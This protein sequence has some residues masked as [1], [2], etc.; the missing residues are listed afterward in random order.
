MCFNLSTQLEGKCFVKLLFQKWIQPFHITLWH[1]TDF[2]ACFTCCQRK[3]K[4]V[5]FNCLPICF[6][7][8]VY[9]SRKTILTKYFFG[10]HQWRR[11]PCIFPQTPNR[12]FPSA[13]NVENI[14]LN[15]TYKWDIEI[16]R[17]NIALY[18][19]VLTIA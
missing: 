6:F 11:W 15:D 19:K 18:T 3:I 7:L 17:F 8:F 4:C 10:L 2:I 13:K 1:R 14:N 5:S 9:L 16:C 12:K